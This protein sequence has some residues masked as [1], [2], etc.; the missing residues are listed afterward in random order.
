MECI[1]FA[2]W[3]YTSFLG[4]T[5]RELFSVVSDLKIFGD[6]TVKKAIQEDFEIRRFFQQVLLIET[7]QILD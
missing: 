4:D 5:F 3:F 1:N 2:N 6:L 7:S